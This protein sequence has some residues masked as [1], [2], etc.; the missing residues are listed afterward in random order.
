MTDDEPSEQDV[1]LIKP[2]LE[3]REEYRRW[4]NEQPYDGVLGRLPA[5]V[6]EP[7]Q[8]QFEIARDRLLY[9]GVYYNEPVNPDVAVGYLDIYTQLGEKSDSPVAPAGAPRDGPEWIPPEFMQDVA[10]L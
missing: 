9:Y 6:P 10:Y 4:R 8:E 1:A 7:H 5:W 3:Q 2:A